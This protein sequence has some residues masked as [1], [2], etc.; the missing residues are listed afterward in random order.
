MWADHALW[1]GGTGDMIMSAMRATNDSIHGVYECQ[2]D[3]AGHP[4]T[5]SMPVPCSPRRRAALLES[6]MLVHA[7]ERARHHVLGADDR[8]RC[9]ARKRRA[10]LRTAP[11]VRLL[12]PLLSAVS[13]VA[14]SSMSSK[15]LPAARKAA[16]SGVPGEHD[17][18]VY[19]GTNAAQ[20]DRSVRPPFC[21]KPP[22]EAV[23]ALCTAEML[24]CC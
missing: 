21:F 7:A 4:A 23:P 16:F 11:T 22:M 14:M 18:D 2:T 10:W 15:A 20:T 9:P 17:V 6:W 24:C 3:R 8:H 1:P 12:L 5:A 13:C 19:S